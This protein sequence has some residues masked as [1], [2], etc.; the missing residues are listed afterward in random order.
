MQSGRSLKQQ[1]Q[2][3]LHPGC[4]FPSIP[5]TAMGRHQW[6]LQGE[7]LWWVWEHKCLLDI[8]TPT[9]SFISCLKS[10]NAFS[11]YRNKILIPIHASS[12][13]FSSSLPTKSYFRLS[14]CSSHTLNSHLPQGLCMCGSFFLERGLSGPNLACSLFLYSPWAKKAFTFLKG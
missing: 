8:Q 14:F 5:G 2:H 4:V 6:Q 7:T 10:P 9:H 13:I 12:L 11:S 3:S 1:T